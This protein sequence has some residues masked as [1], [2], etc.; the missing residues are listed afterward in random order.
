VRP[1]PRIMDTR[2]DGVRREVLLLVVLVLLVDAAFVVVY[3]LADLRRAGGALK[4]GYTALWTGV[5][6]IVVLRSLTRI[7]TERIR[8]RRPG[9]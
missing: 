5:T 2:S 7:R 9:P 1:L 4:L 3:Y 6:L 8:R